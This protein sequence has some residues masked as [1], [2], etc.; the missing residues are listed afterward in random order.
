MPRFEEPD[1]PCLWIQRVVSEAAAGALDAGAATVETYRATAADLAERKVKQWDPPPYQVTLQPV[2]EGACPLMF[3]FDALRTMFMGI[4]TQGAGDEVWTGSLP[5]LEELL[6]AVVEAVVAGRYS[7][8]I[9]HRRLR[10]PRLEGQLRL[11]DGRMLRFTD[12]NGHPRS[13]RAYRIRSCP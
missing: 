13:Y 9:V 1:D 11:A 2:D 4:G 3:T 5:E 6:R 7:E 10:S 8:R 12:V